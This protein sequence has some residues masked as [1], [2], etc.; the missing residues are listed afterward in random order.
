M[1]E[2]A[3]GTFKA[4]DLPL[5]LTETGA[6]CSKCWLPAVAL[7]GQSAFPSQRQL[8][9]LLPA[10]SPAAGPGRPLALRPPGVSA[11][12]V[13][14]SGFPQCTGLCSPRVGR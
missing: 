5:Y 9:Q 3:P 1:W 7:S 6:F 11:G 4:P 14:D 8:S 10:R 13:L 2:V 12:S